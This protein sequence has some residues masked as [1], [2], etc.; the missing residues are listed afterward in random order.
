MTSE[1]LRLKWRSDSHGLQI[2]RLQRKRS[3][4]AQE[5]F[6]SH[7]QSIAMDLKSVNESFIYR[8]QDAH[9]R[10]RECR[11]KAKSNPRYQ[12]FADEAA[13]KASVYDYL[14]NKSFLSSREE[15]LSALRALRAIPA[16]F[17]QYGRDSNEMMA[18]PLCKLIVETFTLWINRQRSF[19]G[20]A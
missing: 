2:A 15:L 11:M 18:P 17:R 1:P 13:A 10:L 5:L 8:G 3:N 9:L 19:S 20:E 7:G 4:S 14:D 6:W 12:W 16:P